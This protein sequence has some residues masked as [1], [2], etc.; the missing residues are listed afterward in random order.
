MYGRHLLIC[1]ALLS[2][3]GCSPSSSPSKTTPAKELVATKVKADLSQPDPSA[4]FWKNL[5]EG[6]VPLIA[7][8]AILPRPSSVTTDGVYVKAA[9]DGTRI[10]FHLRWKD[11][12]KSEG[13]RLG[14][15][16]DAI[17]LQFPAKE[18]TLPSVMMG[19]KGSPVHI[20][21]W[22]A[23]YQR[24]A[25][26]GKPDIKALYPNSS[27][28]MYPLEFKEAKSPPAEE[29]EK[30]AP[31]RAEGN[32]QSFP[33][34]SVDEIFAEGFSTSAVQENHGSIGHGVWA[35]GEWQ[36]VIVRPLVIPGGSTLK[37]GGESGLAFAVWQ[38]GKDEV[39]SRKCLT[40]TWLPLK[41]Q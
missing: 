21:H 15:Y 27:I 8:P 4:A 40:L 38:G 41:V 13:G 10:A 25:E 35:D 34:P 1:G 36:L 32:P 29:A 20:F 24:D 6:Y 5:P 19:S 7:Q 18:G 33:K 2:L 28:D 26:Q 11:T 37:V 31:A 3:L 23:Q 16:S 9:T 12:E 17:A 14:E 30:F 39:G 22:R